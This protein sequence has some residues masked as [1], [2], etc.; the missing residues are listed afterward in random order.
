MT[1]SLRP[2]PD[3]S[4]P[5][6]VDEELAPLLPEPCGESSAL[7]LPELPLDFA[8]S[9]VVSVSSLETAVDFVAAEFSGCDTLEDE[10][11]SSSSNMLPL[12][13]L[14][15]SAG[16]GAAA[17]GLPAVSLPVLLKLIG[18]LADELDGL[19]DELLDASPKTIPTAST[20]AAPTASQR[21]VPEVSFMNACARNDCYSREYSWDEYRQVVSGK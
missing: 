6:P 10:A 18:P 16:E 21:N 11:A 1:L 19:F 17:A 9:D 13:A 4:L 7:E 14:P 20:L 8:E 3:R 15:V 5:D 12:P 2:L